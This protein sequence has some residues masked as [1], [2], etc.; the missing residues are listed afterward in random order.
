MVGLSTDMQVTDHIYNFSLNAYPDKDFGIMD[1]SSSGRLQR[2]SQLHL[3]PEM[4]LTRE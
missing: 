1:M 2:L 4:F 3:F